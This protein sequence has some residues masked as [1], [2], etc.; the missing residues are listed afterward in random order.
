MSSYRVRFDRF[1]II[2]LL[3]QIIH[4]PQKFLCSFR[5]T[6][7]IRKVQ[8]FQDNIIRCAAREQVLLALTTQVV[9]IPHQI[10]RMPC[11]AQ[12]G[13]G[14]QHCHRNNVSRSKG[15]YSQQRIMTFKRYAPV[16]K[17][18]SSAIDSYRRRTDSVLWVPPPVCLL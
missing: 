6:L 4:F 1:W 9:H 5:S 17:F 11:I 3:V 10:L 18:N 14:L 16:L 12:G 7:I 13:I 15:V 8:R 2:A